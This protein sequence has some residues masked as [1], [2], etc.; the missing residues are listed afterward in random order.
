MALPLEASSVSS[1]WMI[2]AKKFVKKITRHPCVGTAGGKVQ[3]VCGKAAERDGGGNG[4][5]GGGGVHSVECGQGKGRAAIVLAALVL[6][7][8]LFTGDHIK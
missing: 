4:G 7:R 6:S 2:N 5:G 3:V 8:Q 1:A